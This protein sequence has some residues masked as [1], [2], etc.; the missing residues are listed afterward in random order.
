MTDTPTPAP[1]KLTLSLPAD[2]A[3][4][5]DAERMK[6]AGELRTRLSTNQMACRIIALGLER[7]P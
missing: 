2:L 3:Q 5:L 1:I 4:R 6:L 7:Q